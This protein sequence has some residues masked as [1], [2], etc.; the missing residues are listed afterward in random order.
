MVT[1]IMVSAKAYMQRPALKSD[2][3]QRLIT[4]LD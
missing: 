2:I 3:K 4:S 1:V